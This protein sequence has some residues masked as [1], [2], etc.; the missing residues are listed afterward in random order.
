MRMRARLQNWNYCNL[1][2]IS[3]DTD[4]LRGRKAKSWVEGISLL[5]EGERNSVV[6]RKKQKKRES[7]QL[8]RYQHDAQPKP[9]IFGITSCSGHITCIFVVV[10]VSKIN[11]PTEGYLALHTQ[12]FG[13]ETKDWIII[14]VKWQFCIV[15][16]AL[17]VHKCY[18]CSSLFWPRSCYCKA[19][20]SCRAKSAA[21]WIKFNCFSISWTTKI[22]KPQ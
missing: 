19:E 2:E 10:H 1:M 20:L 3:T 13:R 15:S 12:W 17:Q 18:S 16:K 4:R 21:S 22:V 5:N 7:R 14:W 11:K 6:G 9:A 8:P